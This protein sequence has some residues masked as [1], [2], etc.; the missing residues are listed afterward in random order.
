MSNFKITTITAIVGVDPVTGDEGI[1]GMKDG[2]VWVPMVFADATRIK[3]LLPIAEKM[4][5]AYKLPYKVLQFSKRE[6][7]TAEAIKEHL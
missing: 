5:K 3:Q 7:I 6:D 1:W 2:Q 4:S